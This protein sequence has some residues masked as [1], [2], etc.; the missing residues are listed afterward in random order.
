MIKMKPSELFEQI[1]VYRQ[2]ARGQ[3]NEVCEMYCSMHQMALIESGKEIGDKNIKI[4]KIPLNKEEYEEIIQSLEKYNS[5]YKRFVYKNVLLS[6]VLFIL[7]FLTLSLGLKMPLYLAG[8]IGIV[9]FL[10]DLYMN[11]KS[12]EKRFK[13]Q[14]V[15]RVIKSVDPE[16]ISLCETCIKQ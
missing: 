10:F 16:V 5:Q 3:K 1:E 8:V 2:V 15:K 12:N 11:G 4:D 9:F 6:I 14:W 13:E 7:L